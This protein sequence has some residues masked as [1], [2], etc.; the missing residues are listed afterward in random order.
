MLHLRGVSLIILIV[1]CC[2]QAIAG[3]YNL[4]YAKYI[5][6]YVLSSSKSAFILP[7]H[8]AASIRSQAISVTQI[9]EQDI[10][11]RR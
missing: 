4:K 1:L 5:T 7:S 3:I 8:E 11:S 10:I 9:E 6:F 2:L